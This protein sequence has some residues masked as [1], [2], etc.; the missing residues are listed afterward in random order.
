MATA[1][2]TT[3]TRATSNENDLR[4]RVNHIEKTVLKISPQID[5]IYKVIVGNEAFQQ[6]GLISRVKRLEDQNE[7]NNALKNKLMGAFFSWWSWLDYYMGNFE[8]SICW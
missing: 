6:E 2:K 5:E 7:K 8:K 3:S 4:N 1:T